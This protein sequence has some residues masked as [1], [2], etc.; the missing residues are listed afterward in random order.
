M[1]LPVYYQR[2]ASNVRIRCIRDPQLKFYTLAFYAMTPSNFNAKSHLLMSR[3]LITNLAVEGQS[4][5]LKQQPRIFIT[6]CTSVNRY[7]HPL[8]LLAAHSHHQSMK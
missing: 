3:L 5:L 2:Q 1:R 6:S 7:M 8:S 4:H